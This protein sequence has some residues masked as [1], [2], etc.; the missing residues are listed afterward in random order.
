MG[1]PDCQHVTTDPHSLRYFAVYL[2]PEDRFRKGQAQTT[3]AV[4][5]AGEDIFMGA[6]PRVETSSGSDHAW[7]GRPGLRPPP[8]ASMARRNQMS[9]LISEPN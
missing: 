7:P 4:A 5:Q 3:H 2:V 1:R 8:S 9:G 6:V